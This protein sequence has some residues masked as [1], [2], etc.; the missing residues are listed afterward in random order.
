MLDLAGEE[1]YLEH[2]VEEARRFYEIM[3][4]VYISFS[5]DKK[6]DCYVK[7]VTINIDKLL[8]SLIKKNK[9]FVFMSG[10]LHSEKVLRE[11][12]GLKEFKVIEAE[13]FNPGTITRLKTGLEKDFKFENFERKKVTREDY[14]KA[15]DKCIEIAKTPVV[16]Q[17]SAFSDLPSEE[18]ILQFNLKNLVSSEELI[19][20][21]KN[22]RE[23]KIVRDFKEGKTKILFTTRCT[24]GIDFP[25]ST[26]NSVVVTK[27][28]YPNTQSLFWKILKK[29]KPNIFWDF[30][31]DKAHRELLQRIYRSVRAN[32]DHVF[33]L[34]PDIRVLNSDVV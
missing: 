7:L 10:T 17:V 31:L 6:G 4:D 3:D 26:C 16:V 21:Q 12:F 15:L 13:G 18:E 5:K 1:S 11:V 23:G 14:L 28:P 22:D 33:L 27:F 9:I 32:D 8:S 24:R 20:Q 34:S 25:F 2:C 29:N 19:E 30:Y